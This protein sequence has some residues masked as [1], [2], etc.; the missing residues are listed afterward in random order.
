MTT[1][2]NNFQTTQTKLREDLEKEHACIP[3]CIAHAQH[4][5]IPQGYRQ[6][7]QAPLKFSLTRSSSLGSWVVSYLRHEQRPSLFH[8][9]ILKCVFK[10][11]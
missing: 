7:S 9:N 5:K 10:K 4:V 1:L 8:Q 3:M 2:Q 11:W 6:G